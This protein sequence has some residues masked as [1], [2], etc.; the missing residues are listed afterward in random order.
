MGAMGID[1]IRQIDYVILLCHDMRAMRA[2]YRDVMHFALEEEAPF[3]IDKMRK[4][5]G[6]KMS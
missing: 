4:F 5:L 2:F 6:K 3:I 1:A